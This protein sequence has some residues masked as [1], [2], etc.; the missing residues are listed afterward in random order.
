MTTTVRKQTHSSLALQVPFEVEPEASPTSQADTPTT[1]MKTINPGPAARCTRSPSL[2]LPSPG[3]RPTKN[4]P[5]TTVKLGSTSTTDRILSTE[6]HRSEVAAA[7]RLRRPRLM[8]N[9]R[10]RHDVSFHSITFS[11][12]LTHRLDQHHTSQTQ[13]RKSGPDSSRTIASRA[14]LFS[15]GQSDG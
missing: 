8:D 5:L 12:G 14:H 15:R 2:R 11:G 10:I 3:I 1:I 6:G 13:R 7:L 4:T 9:L